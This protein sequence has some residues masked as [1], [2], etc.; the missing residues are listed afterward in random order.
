L[1]KLAVFLVVAKFYYST[2]VFISSLYQPIFQIVAVLSIVVGSLSAIYQIKLKRLFAYSAITNTSYLTILLSISD[3]DSIFAFFFY[4]VTY[5]LVMVGIF[6]IFTNLQNWSTGF[7]LSRLS[8]LT[9]FY[10]INPVLA[11]CLLILIF[12][13]AGVPPFLGFFS[14][15]FVFYALISNSNILI[16][17]LIAVWAV[18]STYYYLRVVKLMFFNRN[19]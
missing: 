6:I 12:S 1:P 18:V 4:L 7:Y 5:T 16:A 13:L 19:G 14:K 17:I 15:L 2:F 9:N 3:F 10:E 8:S 11:L